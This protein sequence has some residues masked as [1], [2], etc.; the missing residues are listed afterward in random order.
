ML[1]VVAAPEVHVN[2]FW[3]WFWFWCPHWAALRAAVQAAV[4]ECRYIS[5]W[6][7]ERI[8]TFETNRA[9]WVRMLLG[10]PFEEALGLGASRDGVDVAAVFGRRAL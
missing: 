9:A 7:T 10:A 5:G 6:F 8:G 1:V 4:R 2:T 3:F